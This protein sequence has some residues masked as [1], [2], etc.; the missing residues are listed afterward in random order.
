MNSSRT[1]EK[2]GG[3][4][5]IRVP[6]RLAVVGLLS[7]LCIPVF[8]QLSTPSIDRL[9]PGELVASEG[10]DLPPQGI[11]LRAV[12]PPGIK[13]TKLSEGWVPHL[14]NDAVLYC[15]IGY[16]HLIKKAPC[17]GTEPAEFRSGLTKPRGEELLVADLSSSQY[18]VMVSV[19]V[20]LTDGQFAALTDFVFNIGSANFRK[21]TLLEVVNANQRERVPVQLRR[22]VLAKGKPLAALKTR[23]EREIELFFDGIPKVRAVPRPGEDLSP[24]DIE[25]GQ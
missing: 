20:R 19:K 24:I 25:K 7:I 15:T 23:R 6:V 14:Y 10:R 18:A 12:Y 5:F 22:W 2:H 3:S 16:G 11:S 9:P 4:R 13:V 8:S 1:C 17:N 21:S